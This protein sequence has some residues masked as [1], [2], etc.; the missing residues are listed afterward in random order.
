MTRTELNRFRTM[1]NSKSTE[2]ARQLGRRD[3]IAIDRAPDELDE[4]QFAADRDLTTRNLERGSN[5]LRSVRAALDRIAG[6]SYGTCLECE[7]AIS[8]KRLEAVPW[9]TLCIACQEQ[10]DHHHHPGFAYEERWVRRAA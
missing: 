7:E 8:H 2:L 9:A 3:G 4:I 10:T 1:L 5:L 6:G